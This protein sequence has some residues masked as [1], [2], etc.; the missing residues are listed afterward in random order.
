MKSGKNR[1]NMYF[2]ALLS[3]TL[4]AVFIVKNQFLV[5]AGEWI[6][7]IWLAGFAFLFF[8]VIHIFLVGVISTFLKAEKLKE[9]YLE[10]F[11]K[12]ALVYCIR[13]EDLEYLYERLVWSF[14]GNRLSRCDFWILSDS[15]AEFE[16]FER[17]LIQ[18][19]EE[20][21]KVKIYYRRRHEPRE[22]KQG[23]I[24]EFIVTHPEYDFLYISD[25]DSIVPKRT[26]L[27]LLRKALH[28]S[29]Q[30]IAIFQ[31]FIKTAHSKTYYARFEGMS[32]ETTQRFFF[33]T[34]QALFDRTISFGHQC[35]IRLNMFRQINLPEGLLSHDNWD[36]ALLDQKGYRTVFVDD[37][38]TYDEAPAHY[39]EARKREAR[40]AKGTL[41][42]WPIIFMKGLS[43]QCRFLSFYSVYCYLAQP[44]FF[45]WFLLGLFSQSFFAGELMSFKTDAIWFD[46]FINKALVCILFFSLFV[47]FF[48]KLILVRNVSDFKK[49]IYETSLSF[50]ISG[51]NFL[52]ATWDLLIMPFKKLVWRPMSKDPNEKLSLYDAAKQLVPG[53]L[54]GILGFW[55]LFEGTPNPQWSFVP[56]FVSFIF[57]IPAVYFSA[58]SF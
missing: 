42:G 39:L 52:Y 45:L 4:L 22:R 54:L 26:I 35:L 55:Y 19:I 12:T 2:A 53:T 41:Q 49:F 20:R 7:W 58:K 9:K 5:T 28:P 50:L 34:Y 33:R 11:P 32:S 36:T 29:N 13:N 40:W 25:A 24:K 1:F 27:K 10:T 57:S 16:G 44:V 46:V 23:N 15:D 3:L 48:H 51:G 38:V 30:D 37:V 14:D 47:I 56:L 17:N 21:H 43:P 6:V 31:T 8:N 18:K